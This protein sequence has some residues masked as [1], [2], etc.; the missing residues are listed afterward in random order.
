MTSADGGEARYA[1]VRGPGERRV[2]LDPRRNELALATRAKRP[3]RNQAPKDARQRGR[4]GAPDTSIQRGT[5]RAAQYDSRHG[6]LGTAV[7]LNREPPYVD[8]LL[9]L[10]NEHDVRYVVT[11]SAAAMLHGVALEPG[12]LDVTP[13][14]DHENLTRLAC[15]LRII[16]ARQDPDGKFGRWETGADGQ[17][18]WVEREPSPQDVAARATWQPDPADPASFDYLLQSKY[19][20]IDI[21][22]EVSGPYEELIVRA[23]SVDVNGQTVW[24]EAIQDLLATLTVPRREKD[25]DRVEQLRAM[26]QMR[27]R[28]G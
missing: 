19:G 21:V 15:V 6:G 8:I 13:A 5:P 27:E 14:R 4:I 25:R 2:P 12:D 1:D 16:E 7:R 18:R 20:A 26:Q 23:V 3:S 22:P 10:L 17:H 28:D 11:G 9:N 24:V